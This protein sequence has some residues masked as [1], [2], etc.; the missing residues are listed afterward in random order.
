VSVPEGFLEQFVDHSGLGK[1]DAPLARLCE[2]ESGDD[3]LDDE[4]DLFPIPGEED[5][6]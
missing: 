2:P 5:E 6:S 3:D 1:V 4:F